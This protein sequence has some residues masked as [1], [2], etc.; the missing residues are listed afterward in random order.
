MQPNVC[1]NVVNSLL[2][3]FFQIF[4]LDV[5]NV[6]QIGAAS[7]ICVSCILNVYKFSIQKMLKSW[8][9]E[10]HKL[11]ALCE[12]NHDCWLKLTTT[13]EQLDKLNSSRGNSDMGNSSRRLE[14]ERLEQEQLEQGNIEQGKLEQGQTRFFFKLIAFFFCFLLLVRQVIK[15]S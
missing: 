2:I 11:S 4:V 15:L 8:I 7:S 1:M 10:L 6:R 12:L 9:L 13:Q 3:F 14:Q 5:Q